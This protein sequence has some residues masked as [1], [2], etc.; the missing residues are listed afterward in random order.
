MRDCWV[1]IGDIEIRN[2][3]FFLDTTTK[4]L[5]K[6]LNGRV[7]SYNRQQVTLDDIENIE[8]GEEV[9][10]NLTRDYNAINGNR[11][12]R[13][14]L[15][16]LKL[17]GDIKT[18]PLASVNLEVEKEDNQISKKKAK[19]LEN[20]QPIFNNPENYTFEAVL[21]DDGKGNFLTKN[22]SPNAKKGVV[23][24]VTRKGTEDFKIINLE[25]KFQSPLKIED[26]LTK[27]RF[28]KRIAERFKDPDKELNST[29]ARQEFSTEN[30]A[31]SI[32]QNEFHI[33]KAIKEALKK[34]VKGKEAKVELF[35][36]EPTK[37]RLTNNRDREAFTS[38]KD[39]DG[40]DIYTEVST[41]TIVIGKK[42]KDTGFLRTTVTTREGKEV[43]TATIARKDKWKNKG[44]SDRYMDTLKSSIES[45][46]ADIDA[47][48]N[49]ERSI[50]TIINSD[51]YNKVKALLGARKVEKG[52]KE[53]DKNIY[54]ELEVVGNSP[55]GLIIKN[56][57]QRIQNLE[58]FLETHEIIPNASTDKKF[59]TIKEFN[60]LFDKGQPRYTWE[61]ILYPLRTYHKL[62]DGGYHPYK[63]NK[64]F[65]FSTTDPNSQ[66][67]KE[68]YIE[69]AKKFLDLDILESSD[70]F[71]YDSGKIQ[72]PKVFYNEV[73][74]GNIPLFDSRFLEEVIHYDTYQTL[75]NGID[76]TLEKAYRRAVEVFNNRFD[77]LNTTDL[78]YSLGGYD[79]LNKDNPFVA[80]TDIRKTNE[81]G[82]ITG[83][84]LDKFDRLEQ[85]Q[86]AR[87]I[88][89]FVGNVFRDT[90]SNFYKTV[91][92]VPRT[93]VLQD[94]KNF[95]INL[96]KGIRQGTVE[97]TVFSDVVEFINENKGTVI[98]P[99]S[100]QETSPGEMSDNDMIEGLLSQFLNSQTLPEPI[101][102]KQKFDT[103]FTSYLSS[104]TVNN[105]NSLFK[106]LTR[107]SITREELRPIISGFIPYL[108]N[109]EDS[110]QK[111][112]LN[113]FNGGFSETGASTELFKAIKEWRDST[114]LFNL[115]EVETDET[116]EEI[117]KELGLNVY[118][119]TKNKLGLFVQTNKF[120][121]K[122][123]SILPVYS[124]RIMGKNYPAVYEDNI[125]KLYSPNKGFFF[126][127]K[128]F[129]GKDTE[130]ILRAIIDSDAPI[131][132]SLRETFNLQDEIYSDELYNK[133]FPLLQNLFNAF[134]TMTINKMYKLKNL[135][136]LGWTTIAE[137]DDVLSFYKGK[138]QSDFTNFRIS[139][140][141]SRIFT[142]L[143]P[144]DILKDINSSE[145]T[146]TEFAEEY[147]KLLRKH[148]GWSIIESD[149]A[150]S[151][152]AAK[153][154]LASL[155]KDH[156]KTAYG[157]PGSITNSVDIR[158]DKE[159]K[160]ENITEN[161]QTALKHVSAF[162]RDFIKIHSDFIE[163]VLSQTKANPS[164]AR[165]QAGVK[166]ASIHVF[167][168]II[169]YLAEGE[170]TT[171]SWIFKNNDFFKQTLTAKNNY[172]F[173]IIKTAGIEESDS[174]GTDT[175]DLS[176]KNHLIMNMI[177][178]FKNGWK[179]L[180]RRETKSK[181][182]ALQFKELVPGEQGFVYETI[183][184]FKNFTESD[185]KVYLRDMLEAQISMTKKLLVQDRKLGKRP[186]YNLGFLLGEA[187]TFNNLDKVNDEITGVEQR[188]IYL[189]NIDEKFKTDLINN[190]V[191]QQYKDF[192]KHIGEKGITKA[193]IAKYL[194]KEKE[195]IKNWNDFEQFKKDYVV[196]AVAYNI[197]ESI[198]LSGGIWQIPDWYKRAYLF[199]SE[200]RHFITD[201]R[202][203]TQ[204]NEG[205]YF[206]HR[207]DGYY[208][209]FLIKEAE[210]NAFNLE[211]T[212]DQA[213]KILEDSNHKLYP[214][215]SKFKNTFGEVPQIG[216]DII[217]Q[218]VSNKNLKTEEAKFNALDKFANYGKMDIADAQ[219]FGSIDFARLTYK[220]LGLWTSNH[221]TWFNYQKAYYN[222]FIKGETSDENKKIIESYTREFPN[223]DSKV[224]MGLL[225]FQY[226][227]PKTNGLPNETTIPILGSNK[228]AIR[229]MIPSN[230]S[231]DS[232]ALDVLRPLMEQGQ[233]YGI[234]ESGSKFTKETG[235][236]EAKSLDDVTSYL[237]HYD[238][239][240]LQIDPAKKYKKEV[241]F[242]SQGRALLMQ[243][244]LDKKMDSA[245]IESY[246]KATN[247]YTQ[248]KI[249]L[250]LSELGVSK[251]L[252][253]TDYGFL[254]SK[255]KEQVDK[256]D[257][258][259][260][261]KDWIRINLEEIKPD[262]ENSS[263]K[264]DLKNLLLGY[265]QKSIVYQKVNGT[266]LEQASEFMETIG[267]DN[268]VKE[269]SL[270]FYSIKNGK[271]T[272]AEAILTWSE[273]WNGLLGRY[274]FN[275]KRFV[276][277]S[278]VE[279]VNK[280]I[281]L[282]K[283][284]NFD[285]GILKD[286]TVFAWRTPN[287]GLASMESFQIKKFLTS[288]NGTQVIVPKEIVAKAG[289]DFDIDKLSFMF[290]MLE[291]ESSG[292]ITAL[293]ESKKKLNK[294]LDLYKEKVSKFLTKFKEK[295][296]QQD[297]Q[298]YIELNRD[299][300]RIQK[301]E[302]YTLE[303]FDKITEVESRLNGLEEKYPEFDELAVL[304]ESRNKIVDDIKENK[305]EIKATK[306]YYNNNLLRSILSILEQKENFLQLVTPLTDNDVAQAAEK[307]LERLNKERSDKVYVN[308]EKRLE[309]EHLFSQLGINQ[310][311]IK[312]ETLH[313]LKAMLGVF[314]VSNKVWQIYRD[315]QAEGYISSVAATSLLEMV[316]E[317]NY[318][319]VNLGEKEIP[320]YVLPNKKLIKEAWK[321]YEDR[322]SLKQFENFLVERDFS[323]EK[324]DGGFKIIV[325]NNNKNVNLSTPF[326]NSLL[327]RYINNILIKVKFHLPATFEVADLVSVE[328]AELF[329]QLVSITVDGSKNP[330]AAYVNYLKNNVG[331]I[332]LMINLGIPVQRITDF[333]THPEV[334]KLTDSEKSGNI[335]K[336]KN[337]TD[338]QK[339]YKAF[340]KAS[341]NL[342][343]IQ[344]FLN[345]DTNTIST[346]FELE[347]KDR[348]KRGNEFFTEETIRKIEE[349]SIISS[350]F[351]TREVISGIMTSLFEYS[352]DPRVM[353]LYKK[354]YDDNEIGR[355]KDLP[356]RFDRVFQ[357]ELIEYLIIKSNNI[358]VNKVMKLG[359]SKIGTLTKDIRERFNQIPPIELS[360]TQQKNMPNANKVGHPSL[361]FIFESNDKEIIDYYYELLNK[362]PK[363]TRM[364]IAM[365][366]FFQQG[367]RKTPYSANELINP[368]DAK[369]F[370]KIK[371]E[372]LDEVLLD[373]E[374]KFLE[375]HPEFRRVQEVINNIPQYKDEAK[376]IPKYRMLS[377]NRGF[378]RGKSNKFLSH[379]PYSK[380][381]F[382]PKIVTNSMEQ[383]SLFN[384]NLE[385]LGVKNIPDTGLSIVKSN[386]FID[387]LQ[388]LIKSQAY[389][390]NRAATANKMFS[391]GLRWSRVNQDKV[392]VGDKRRVNNKEAE[393]FG[394]KP[395]RVKINQKIN[396][397]YGYFTHD[398][399]GNLLPD[400]SIVKPIIDFLEEK[401]GIDMSNYD[402]MLA[403][404]YEQGSFIHQH[405]DTTESITAVNYPVI[406]INL[407]ADGKLVYDSRPGSNYQ[408]FKIDGNLSL[409]NG[410][411][412][413][414]G[415]NGVNRF[416]F[417]HR[418]ASTL[419]SNTPTKPIELPSGKILND[420]RITLTFRRAKD[421]EANM[422]KKPVEITTQ[423]KEIY[424]S[425]KTYTPNI[426]IRNKFQLE[427]AKLAKSKGELFSGRIKVLPNT[428]FG[429]PFSS[430][431]KVLK[432]NPSLIKTSNPKES[433]IKY[434]DWVLTS[435]DR[436][437]TWIR[438]EI[439]SGKHKGKPIVYFN[440]KANKQDGISHATALS[441]LI[442]HHNSPLKI[443]E[444]IG[445]EV[446]TKNRVPNA[447][448]VKAPFKSK[449]SI[450]FI[451]FGSL[452]SST[453]YYAQQYKEKGLPVNPE[454]Y[455][456]GKVYFASQNGGSKAKNSREK[457][458]NELV[459][460][461]E[462]G[463]KVLLDSKLYIDSSSY[464]KEGEGWLYSQ[465]ENKKYKQQ[466]VS[467]KNT[468]LWY[469]D[470]NF[471][472]QLSLSLKSQSKLTLEPH[473][474]GH[475]IL[476]DGKE[477]GIVTSL[478]NFIQDISLIE[479]YKGL[480][481]IVREE[482]NK[483]N[484]TYY[485]TL[486]D[487]TNEKYI[488]SE[489][490]IRDLSARIADRIGIE[491][492]Y[493]SDRSKKY[494]GKLEGNIATINLAY[495]TLDT[496]I[497]EI[498]G[499]PIIRAIRNKYIKSTTDDSTGP[500]L[501]KPIKWNE[502]DTLYQNLLK[503][504]EYGKGKEVFDRVKK[505]YQY[506]NSIEKGS[507]ELGDFRIR[508]SDTAS[509]YFDTLEEAK[510][511][512]IRKYTLAEQQE[513]AIV[514]LLG[515]MTADKLN[516]VKDGKLI[517]LL[518][519]LLKEMKSF[520]RSLFRQKEIDIDS[521]PDNMTLNDL[522]DLLAY[523]N[524]KLILPGNTI[525][526][527]TPDDKKFKTYQE[528]SNHISELLK[529]NSV[530]LDTIS[531]IPN[532]FYITD[533]IDGMYDITIENINGT[534]KKIK[535]H[536]Y[537]DEILEEIVTVKEVKELYKLEASSKSL[538]N[539]ISKNKEYEQSKEIIEEWKKVN[540][541]KYD[542]E[543]VYSRG[544]G[545]YSVAEAYSDFDVELMFQNLLAHIE[546]NQKAGG[547][548]AISAF[549]KPVDKR[550]RHIE[551]N[552]G[553][554][555]FK[556][557]PKSEDILWASN[558][559]VYS[560]SVWDAAE[561]VNKDTKSEL[562]GVSY[563][564]YPALKSIDSVQPNLANIIDNIAHKHNELGIELDGNNFRLEYDND[565]PY[566]TKKILDN[567]NSILDQK[568]GR[569]KNI[570]IIKSS[571]SNFIIRDMNG[572]IL[573]S[574][575]S[576]KDA[577][578]NLKDIESGSDGFIY[579]L[580][581][582]EQPIGKQPTQTNENLK[583]SIKEVKTKLN[584]PLN[585]LEEYKIVFNKEV[586][587]GVTIE[588]TV[589]PNK[590]FLKTSVISETFKEF[591]TK[592]EGEKYLEAEKKKLG[593][594]ITDKEYINQAEINTKI[595]ALKK[596]MRKYPRV[597]IRS[598][599]KSNIMNNGLY[600]QK[601]S[602]V[603]N[604][605]N[606]LSQE[607]I[608]E[609]KNCNGV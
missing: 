550:L 311:I 129:A 307:A 275:G 226:T 10:V 117:E 310:D 583:K 522:A 176:P 31:E 15:R 174:F 526:Y 536:L 160:L 208:N 389:V 426:V 54:M 391:A 531:N 326:G 461:L 30:F 149:E 66:A 409:T 466:V 98:N 507:F 452:D 38:I 135:D 463:A 386:E 144:D 427:G 387:L 78:L 609:I 25:G 418:I 416:N 271:I 454:V 413:A 114:D 479:E 103:L 582:I 216:L 123:S 280:A 283:E 268:I 229:I 119:D 147:I 81:S 503:E 510:K 553:K 398:Q 247:E 322:L 542:P 295:A 124:T 405:R 601:V 396:S 441:Y 290:P 422:P 369:E 366:L 170:E 87:I 331:M 346:P 267:K 145:K 500:R 44:V 404:I 365:A 579:G 373:F 600:L 330:I 554:I 496:P 113:S 537:S 580:K 52:V 126:M 175:K 408:Q 79:G 512:G 80:G 469:K 219:A 325:Q 109:L 449:N 551:G 154:E 523:R 534:W 288:D 367:F 239:L 506:K 251:D 186:Y 213:T 306:A 313:S 200:G 549:T 557:F 222:E 303:D 599:V 576:R 24:K 473:N 142:G 104:H 476:L 228:T 75:L 67:E 431:E 9:Y 355:N 451:G 62:Q 49:E 374:E 305:K 151:E 546:D 429:N 210:M 16:F 191:T 440:T 240:K 328:K 192:N 286:I 199:T 4:T 232:P 403:N 217:N 243:D 359:L 544:N 414:F 447:E 91:L 595:D 484:N 265:I 266:Q 289:S 40:N 252:E 439:E 587:S 358:D 543:E 177:T 74:K 464:N 221:D 319:E 56:R 564:K 139:K 527:T 323:I 425:L 42:S 257:V 296:I 50:T 343:N 530:D 89:E 545:F 316:G 575:D 607:D 134:G 501:L 351:K 515:L 529:L 363:E 57:G 509:M 474:L 541:I 467:N 388:P 468:T 100:E 392:P 148:F 138:F 377:D 120:I 201:S 19:E 317:N 155:N 206:Q 8:F 158:S 502:P 184:P 593:K 505:D 118:G 105:E 2:P 471:G 99:V 163:D 520:M 108:R 28:F 227:G 458:L 244:Y 248:Y 260:N 3:E 597:L 540:N 37:G 195:D 308:L 592:E 481:N 82:E 477:I 415:V 370:L 36:S 508:T 127:F 137:Y 488:A 588:P 332:S 487:Q 339:Q 437:A 360:K 183:N 525:E 193:D 231:A 125:R 300:D 402:A 434:I 349:E 128:E 68:A 159:S 22:P 202:F 63:V 254:M 181:T 490:T 302:E 397:Q 519:R 318:S 524:S 407:G 218:I 581:I 269:D 480:E 378:Q 223:G 298:R 205:A 301:K 514:E 203:L 379:Y 399:N 198:L 85:P 69:Y 341:S 241:I 334:L 538:N 423:G 86:K 589:T 561:K 327:D 20:L 77:S 261:V 47:R 475:K 417:H 446:K 521:L 376:T 382:A 83:V 225:K 5:G 483:I 555:R 511:Y 432:D 556:I 264:Q 393:G 190:F 400:I 166:K 246:K 577:Q 565:I 495:A 281:Q 438:K 196:K 498:L 578:L 130:E 274:D 133:H 342:F 270:K 65:T 567:I 284:G 410:G 299:L 608:N 131:A 368:E 238:F 337:L 594:I 53:V 35:P 165:E 528:A 558:I 249:D 55:V 250:L 214:Y 605:I 350:F 11:T 204:V 559:D 292:N 517:S 188:I 107:N 46:L 462:S 162:H 598:E 157:L 340:K 146:G 276:G 406:V 23:V 457:T 72:V 304:K 570:N 442:N 140:D 253:I 486:N 329:N 606:N 375:R 380:K 110:K 94:I 489:K 58:Q 7:P 33:L 152:I 602:E 563:S 453:Q 460:A 586:F 179:E 73:K 287:Q 71:R 182:P 348:F 381:Q 132:K 383:L 492:E 60:L 237:Q 357:Q 604:I 84:D 491:V 167:N 532:K 17:K 224:M 172:K 395:N 233:A 45:V 385:S 258:H 435:T 448:K 371:P 211:G 356:E 278:K 574:T 21:D 459:K 560:G 279:K 336:E 494:K 552:G 235:F 18:S 39:G 499:H 428:H 455:E 90:E 504:L 26:D 470:G 362:E 97:N 482:F 220:S 436:R 272:S 309:S 493:D 497:H 420:Y 314:A 136:F 421:L 242:S 433:V 121:K 171:H 569:L 92:T 361:N 585:S 43:V 353:E 64:Y 27:L 41:P 102:N 533:S 143:N 450:G 591:D 364:K 95:I 548:F 321:S 596:G 282:A 572:D 472:Q 32:I 180:T 584:T 173:E 547:K 13:V 209:T 212:T 6:V 153:N 478:D 411:V 273:N 590:W 187:D 59:S 347:M 156:F 106:I 285:V 116:T 255:L 297:Y 485:Q 345:P 88:A 324:I 207:T 291:Q 263:V 516:S 390:E 465:L 312:A 293:M 194:F 96:I 518:K 419:D 112:F 445:F 535:E 262:F 29:R 443:A 234:M 424:E 169:N 412:Y 294:E 168:S 394:T 354:I 236:F 277:L 12:N 230:Y 573:Y 115:P 603:D 164:G 150:I 320:N 70:S 178:M 256:R 1:K 539:F 338:K 14:P 352:F 401:I 76:P 61:D 51:A 189:D 315:V 111:S 333:I 259:Q 513:E 141:E 571:K 122:L 101:V 335:I 185:L 444:S 568:Y 34:G 245:I 430:D 48:Q 562:L 215:V 384:N 161:Q 344:Q 197:E 566:S 93:T 372:L 456:S